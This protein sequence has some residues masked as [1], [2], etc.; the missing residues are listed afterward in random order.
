MKIPLDGAQEYTVPGTGKP[1]GLNDTGDCIG[2]DAR[3]FIAFRGLVSILKIY[4][5]L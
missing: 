1:R 3:W 5:L 2:H 4:K